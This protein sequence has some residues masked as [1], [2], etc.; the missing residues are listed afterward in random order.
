M[1]TEL[2]D[3]IR[4]SIPE[5][6]SLINDANKWF[7]DGEAFYKRA[8]ANKNVEAEY[9]P[10]KKFFS[11]VDS[12]E[13]YVVF[14]HIFTQYVGWTGGDQRYQTQE[15]YD[16][17]LYSIEDAMDDYINALTDFSEWRSTRDS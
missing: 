2:L 3:E 9:S 12:S 6:D 11:A 14:K 5:V 7:R 16:I 13:V 4:S 10:A 1:N 17:A 15:A 8:L